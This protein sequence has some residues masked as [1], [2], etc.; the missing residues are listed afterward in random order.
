MLTLQTT[1][2]DLAAMVRNRRAVGSR[3]LKSTV[4]CCTAC[5]HHTQRNASLAR[6]SVPLLGVG[7]SFSRVVSSAAVEPASARN[8]EWRESGPTLSEAHSQP[9]GATDS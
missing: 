3:L 6:A 1:A 9:H 4:S 8:G 2:G 5:A 7:M